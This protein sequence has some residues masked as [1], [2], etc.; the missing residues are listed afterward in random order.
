MIFYHCSLFFITLLVF[1]FVSCGC[2]ELDKKKQINWFNALTWLKVADSSQ[3]QWLKTFHLYGGFSRSTSAVGDLVRGSVR[4][5]QAI[6][7]PYKGFTVRRI[8]KGRILNGILIRQAYKTQLKSGNTIQAK[9]NNVVILKDDRSVLIKHI[10]GP[11]FSLLRKRKF[12]TL[13]R[14]FI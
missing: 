6:P 9:S 4:V 3:A 2:K 14:S 13:F 11:C 10:V 8:N 12:I 1:F 7:D 5:I